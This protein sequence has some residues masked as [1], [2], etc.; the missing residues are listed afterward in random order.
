VDG[1]DNNFSTAEPCP[2]DD[3]CRFREKCRAEKLCC[4][5]FGL[6]LHGAGQ[7]RWSLAPRA[8]NHAR[9]EALL[10]LEKRPLGRVKKVRAAR[11]LQRKRAQR[12]APPLAA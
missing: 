12:G 1:P 9:F 8:P 3:G 5:R 7:A 2:C 10:D 11:K 4:E 6:Y